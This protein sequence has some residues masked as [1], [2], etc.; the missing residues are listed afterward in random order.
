MTD[1]RVSSTIWMLT[2]IVLSWRNSSLSESVPGAVGRVA[3]WDPKRKSEQKPL[4]GNTGHQNQVTVFTVGALA[5]EDDSH[6]IF[7]YL[8]RCLLGDGT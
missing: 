4:R 5:S 1:I 3:T 6:A 8:G 7:S 2:V